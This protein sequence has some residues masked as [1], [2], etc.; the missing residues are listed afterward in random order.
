MRKRKTDEEIKK[1]HEIQVT[2]CDEGTKGG[3]GK[4][5][6]AATATASCVGRSRTFWYG[7]GRLK[8]EEREWF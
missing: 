1:K 3:G 2:P 6:A 8:E 4:E 5:E 7:I